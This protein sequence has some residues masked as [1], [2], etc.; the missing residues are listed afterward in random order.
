M[1]QINASHMDLYG[2]DMDMD[3][4]SPLLGDGGTLPFDGREGD[5][6]G[7]A[8]GAAIDVAVNEYYKEND[9]GHQIKTNCINKQQTNT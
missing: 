2:M 5:S 7:A 9:N 8:V 6:K 4:S 1:G 3:A